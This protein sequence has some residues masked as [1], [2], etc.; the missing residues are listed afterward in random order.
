M[1]AGSYFDNV[2]FAHLISV[3]HGHPLVCVQKRNDGPLPTVDEN[4]SQVCRSL[5]AAFLLA[6]NMRGLQ[7][8]EEHRPL[9]RDFVYG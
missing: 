3:Q 1:G 2:V 4:E 5:R 8:P 9:K 6:H 7:E